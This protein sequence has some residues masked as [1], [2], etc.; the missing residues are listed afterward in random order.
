MLQNQ[1]ANI[2]VKL[3]IKSLDWGTFFRDIQAGRFQLYGL[4][5]VGIRNPEIYEKIFSSQNL[6]ENLSKINGEYKDNELVQEVTNFIS[7]DKKRPIC[8]PLKN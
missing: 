4:T 2:G 1:L 5:W 8:S 7:K 3:I 6:H